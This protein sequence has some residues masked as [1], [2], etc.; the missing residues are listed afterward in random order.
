MSLRIIT[1]ARQMIG[2]DFMTE[3]CINALFLI[4]VSPLVFRVCFSIFSALCPNSESVAHATMT[5]G[6]TTL[7][8]EPS[9]Y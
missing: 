6:I 7:C 5:R 8:I 2:N 9:R 4:F 1:I 3:E